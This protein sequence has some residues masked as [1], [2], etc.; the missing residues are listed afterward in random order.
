MY[1]VYSTF[2]VVHGGSSTRCFR[3]VPGRCL[4][5][6]LSG[7][8]HRWRHLSFQQVPGSPFVSWRQ[9]T[10]ISY[11]PSCVKVENPWSS[12]RTKPPGYVR[13]V[14]LP[15]GS[16]IWWWFKMTSM[17]FDIVLGCG[18]FLPTKPGSDWNMVEPLF[19]GSTKTS[20]TL[21]TLLRP[22]GWT[23]VSTH[24][25][26]T[27]TWMLTKTWRDRWEHHRSAGGF[28]R[29]LMSVASR[30]NPFLWLI[31]NMFYCQP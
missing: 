19:I 7:E 17:Y 4:P 26:L 5:P 23:S 12:Q 31:S 25:I 9:G 11:A 29:G 6:Q 10:D 13:H 3:W 22:G 24:V 1:S 30:G 14:W 15:E 8:G 18:W 20:F 2:G 16:L 21:Y 28:F 27:G